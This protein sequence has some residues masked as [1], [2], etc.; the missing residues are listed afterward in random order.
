VAVTVDTY[1]QIAEVLALLSLSAL[2]VY[3]IVTLMRM[4]GLFA[5]IQQDVAELTKAVKPV[6]ENLGSVSER[7][8][9]ITAKV[10]DQVL[11]FRE[12]FESMKRMVD[13]VEEFEQRLIGQIEEPVSRISSLIG[14]I[15]SKLI[16]YVSSRSSGKEAD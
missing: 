4:N 7:L 15:L 1:V 6:L 8:K 16:G 11:L 12:S 5:S 14:A 2:C 13:N 10:D 9:S 3:L